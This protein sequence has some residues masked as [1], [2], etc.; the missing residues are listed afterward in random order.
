[1]TEAHSG[2]RRLAQV[3]LN[4]LQLFISPIFEK[5]VDKSLVGEFILPPLS[6]RV[7]GEPDIELISSNLRA[8]RSYVNTG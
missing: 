4:L 3:D 1:M 8:T 2:I 6:V 7:M 5:T